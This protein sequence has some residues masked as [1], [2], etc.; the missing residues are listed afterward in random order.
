MT[1]EKTYKY[2]QAT[3]K[4]KV[5]GPLWLD[6]CTRVILGS[7]LGRVTNYRDLEFSWFSSVLPEYYLEIYKP[8]T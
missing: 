6:N 7:N 8:P 4:I 3:E 5:A 2:I 1:H